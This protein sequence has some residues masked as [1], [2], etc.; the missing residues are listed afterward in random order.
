IQP[1][2]FELEYTNQDGEKETPV[3]IHKT[4]LGSIER[5]LS[6]YIEHRAGKFPFWLAPEQIRVLTIN[7]DVKDY[8]DEITTILDETILMKPIKYNEIRYSLDNRS[9]SIGKKIREARKMRI[10]VILIVG[11]KDE[12]SRSVSIRIDDEEQAIELSKLSSFINE[13]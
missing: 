2:R 11:P 5:F 4:I 12:A 10:P 7:D 1:D 13:S 8:V 9:E 6:V 3:M